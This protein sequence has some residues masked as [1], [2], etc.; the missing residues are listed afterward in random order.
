MITLKSPRATLAAAMALLTGADPA[1]QP[2]RL[3]LPRLFSRYRPERHRAKLEGPTKRYGRRQRLR[4]K[5]IN[6]RNR[7]RAQ[8]VAR[9]VYGAVAPLSHGQRIALASH[10]RAQRVASGMHPTRVRHLWVDETRWFLSGTG[11]W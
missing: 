10:M 7:E 5:A 1:N 11:Q 8:R 4:H 9:R 2:P 3:E 6:R